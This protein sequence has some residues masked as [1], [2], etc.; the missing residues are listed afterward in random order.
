MKRYWIRTVAALLVTGAVML[1][2]VGAAFAKAPP[3]RSGKYSVVPRVVNQH[4]K[5]AG[6]FI[7]HVK[8]GKRD[9][10]NPLKSQ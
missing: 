2:G 8:A 3:A 6:R 7:F 5:T 4:S 9:N 10:G 1:V